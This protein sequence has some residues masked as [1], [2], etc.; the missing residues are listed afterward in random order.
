MTYSFMSLRAKPS[1]LMRLLQNP[2]KT[3]IEI[4]FVHDINRFNRT[5]QITKSTRSTKLT[6]LREDYQKFE[7]FKALVII[8]KERHHGIL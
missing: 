5:N 2:G 6:I 1:N 8:V 4:K 7:K 3:L